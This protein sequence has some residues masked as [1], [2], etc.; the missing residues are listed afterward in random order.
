MSTNTEQRIAQLKKQHKAAVADMRY[1]AEAGADDTAFDRAEAEAKRLTSEIG[2]LQ[3]EAKD[4]AE[5]RAGLE[6]TM[7]Q[8]GPNRV[9]YDNA[10]LN[11]YA[12]AFASAIR[13][14]NPAPIEVYSENPR[15]NYQPGLEYR[16]TLKSTATQAMPVS[17]YD[18][19]VQSLVESSAVLNAG[20]TVLTTQTGEDL[21]VP[22]NTANSTAAIT[23]EGASIS[24]SDPTQAVVTLKSYKYATFFQISNELATDTPL[25]LIGY[26]AR[27]AGQALATAFGP[28]L[29][30]G[31]GTGQPTGIVTGAS[32]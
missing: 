6:A 13:S 19:I 25:D 11:E 23:N 16:T 22:K 31:T 28:H 21:Q 4:D 15:S 12:D 1:L 26:L 3:R 27:Q 18:Q 30:T 32:D 24:A 14:K 20:A 8:L 7:R 29:I 9:T 10:D 17:V 5:N 2:Q